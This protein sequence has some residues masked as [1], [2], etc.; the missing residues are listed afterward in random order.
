[1]F[2]VADPAGSSPVD[3]FL[4]ASP[5]PDSSQIVTFLK[6]FTADDRNEMA[7]QLIDRGI[8]PQLVSSA[9]V[10]LDASSRLSSS[11]I[12]GVLTIASAAASAYH[13]Y[14]R[15]QS[16]GWAAVWFGAGIVFPLFTPVIAVAQGFGREAK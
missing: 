16:I 4:L 12:M 8:S 5:N 6:P 11:K 1:M 10:W 15:N 9:L 14:R 3:A 2:G 13:G 7:R